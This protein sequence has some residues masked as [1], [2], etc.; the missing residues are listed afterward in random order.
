MSEDSADKKEINWKSVLVGVII[1]TI[2]VGLGLLIYLLLQPKPELSSPPAKVS[3]ESA[4]ELLEQQLSEE[5]INKIKNDEADQRAESN[6]R[7]IATAVSACTTVLLSK[8]EQVSKIYSVSGGCG[9]YDYLLESSYIVKIPD[10]PKPT[11]KTDSANSIICI[12][13]EGGSIG[14]NHW[15]FFATDDA[16]VILAN[17]GSKQISAANI[18]LLDLEGNHKDCQQL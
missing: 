4:K 8:N 18:S 7:S 1:G 13:A 5:E 2:L 17:G 9:N 6:V 12:W 16:K 10:N 3:T 14:Q 11:L 15:V